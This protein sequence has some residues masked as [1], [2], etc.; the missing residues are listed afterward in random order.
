MSVTLMTTIK[1]C[2]RLF[3]E[4]ISIPKHPTHLT[5]LIF[6]LINSSKWTPL[7]NLTIYTSLEM[8][9]KSVSKSSEKVDGERFKRI[10][11]KMMI[12][13]F[14]SWGECRVVFVEHLGTRGVVLWRTFWR[15]SKNDRITEMWSP[16]CLHQKISRSVKGCP[17]PSKLTKSDGKKW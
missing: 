14:V 7:K 15:N 9:K 6:T 2:H 16:K 5:D 11:L 1:M 8:K 17:C 12:S 4:I 13:F 3:L 10:F